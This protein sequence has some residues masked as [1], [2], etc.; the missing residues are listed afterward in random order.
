MCNQDSN[1][2]VYRVSIHAPREGNAGDDAGPASTGQEAPVNHADSP[3]YKFICFLRFC[4]DRLNKGEPVQ[5]IWHDFQEKG[6]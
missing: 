1:P 2:K 4:A 6:C 5:A 3:D